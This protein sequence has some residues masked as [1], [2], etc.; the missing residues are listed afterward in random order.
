MWLLM[1]L[2]KTIIPKPSKLTEK[3]L[4]ASE[5]SLLTPIVSGFSSLSNPKH[6]LSEVLILKAMH[7]LGYSKFHAIFVL[8][9][10]I[11]KLEFYR[12]ADCISKLMQTLS[13]WL[14]RLESEKQT[15]RWPQFPVANRQN[16]S[17]PKT[18]NCCI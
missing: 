8:A 6:G 15:F 9:H 10:S 1:V 18:V 3:T 5:P 4:L 12:G 2:T 13:L 11:E 7:V 17:S 14:K 16:Y